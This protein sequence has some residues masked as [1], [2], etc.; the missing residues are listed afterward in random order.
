[1]EESEPVWKRPAWITAIVG[2]VSVILTV[3]EISSKY[4]EKEQ[5]ILLAKLEKKQELRLVGLE[6]EQELRLAELKVESKRIENQASAQQYEFEIVNNILAQKGPERVFVLRYLAATLDNQEARNWAAKEVERL[7][8]L[9]AAKSDLIELKQKLE[10][11]ERI[12]AKASNSELP[13]Q[14]AQ[15]VLNH[16]RK[17]L[18]ERGVK[19]VELGWKAGLDQGDIESR[20]GFDF[21][22]DFV[23]E[24][25]QDE[26]SV[27]PVWDVVANYANGSVK[28]DD[29]EKS[30]EIKRGELDSLPN[31]IE[32]TGPDAGWRIESYLVTQNRHNRMPIGLVDYQ[33]TLG[34]KNN[35]ICKLKKHAELIL[36]GERT[37]MPSSFWVGGQ[38]SRLMCPRP[39]KTES[40]SN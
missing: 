19:V 13:D 8:E 39:E 36:L 11:K 23:V 2:L 15:L 22:V 18:L 37:L 29:I 30:F 34:E 9:V 14:R 5:A 10:E 38:S 12:I 17:D 20:K 16:L 1:M 4:F 32:V 33:C 28:Y 7:D 21:S 6:K 25:Y 31:L 26:D 3:P 40:E 35:H 27:R 24:K